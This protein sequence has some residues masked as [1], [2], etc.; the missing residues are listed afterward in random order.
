MDRAVPIKDARKY[1]FHV[2]SVPDTRDISG[3]PCAESSATTAST[4]C[5]PSAAS[6]RPQAKDS[7]RLCDLYGVGIEIQQ[8]VLQDVNPPD[9]VKPAFKK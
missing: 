3:P 8:L 4:R 5:S 9:P 6:H 2:R 1:L 7:Q